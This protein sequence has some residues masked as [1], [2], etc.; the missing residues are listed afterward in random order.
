M[1]VNLAP[2]RPKNL[3]AIVPEQNVPLIPEEDME[4]DEEEKGTEYNHGGDIGDAETDLNSVF[5]DVALVED[6]TI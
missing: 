3:R 5:P 4:M 1:S 6:N 2:D